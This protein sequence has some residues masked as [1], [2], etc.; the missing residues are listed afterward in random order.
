LIQGPAACDHESVGRVDLLKYPRY[1]QKPLKILLRNQPTGA[2]NNFRPLSTT[3]SHHSFRE[4]IANH[5]NLIPRDI[6]EFHQIIPNTSRNGKDPVRE[7]IRDTVKRGDKWGPRSNRIVTVVMGDHD[8]NS[9]NARQR[10]TQP[11][12]SEQVTMH[13]VV[14]TSNQHQWQTKKVERHP[15]PWGQ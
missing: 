4:T 8:R 7:P 6:F 13:Y 11:I 2:S 14:P 12:R 3:L 9:E 1:S 5:L 10:F 15:S